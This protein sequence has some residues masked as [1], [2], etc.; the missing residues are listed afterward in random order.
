MV[1]RTD[2]PGLPGA[3]DT[4]FTLLDDAFEDAEWAD[5]LLFDNTIEGATYTANQDGAVGNP[6]PS[7]NVEHSWC[8][9]GVES[10][11]MAVG[12]WHQAVFDPTGLD[13]Q[14]IRFAFDVQALPVGLRPLIKQGNEVYVGPPQIMMPMEGSGL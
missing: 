6:A 4:L 9:D 3:A 11:S 12:H 5:S 8:G 1:T 7:R 13:V 14:A 10:R 2:V